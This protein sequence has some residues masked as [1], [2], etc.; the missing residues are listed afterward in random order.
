MVTI[1]IK[2]RQV[3]NMRD[4]RLFLHRGEHTKTVIDLG[5]RRKLPSELL[6]VVDRLVVKHVALSLLLALLI[7]QLSRTN[8]S[9]RDGQRRILVA[10]C[11]LEAAS[12]R[13]SRGFGFRPRDRVGRRA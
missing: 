10:W 9:R 2:R 5:I 6:K 4:L 8:P 1:A 3:S 7:G 11:Q 12:E 13:L